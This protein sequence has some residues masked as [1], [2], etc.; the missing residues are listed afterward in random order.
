MRQDTLKVG[1]LR[2]RTHSD[3]SVDI[4]PPCL[5]GAMRRVGVP[6]RGMPA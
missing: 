1:P 4:N 2:K 6:R 3:A 5:L